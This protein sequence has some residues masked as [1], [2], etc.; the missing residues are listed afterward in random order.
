MKQSTTLVMVGF[1]C[2]RRLLLQRKFFS[3]APFN[4]SIRGRWLS[5]KLNSTFK[6]SD[7]E[8]QLATP[9]QLKPKPDELIFGKNFTDH[10]IQIVHSKALGGWQPPRILPFQ[11]ISLHPAAKVFHYAFELFEGMKA[12]RGVDGRIRLFRPDRNMERMNRSAVAAVLPTFDGE[13][14]V[15]CIR[16]LIEIDQEWVPHSES[17]S[18]Y[19]RPT[20]IG[21]D[22]TLGVGSTDSALLFV[23]L[24]PVGPY[25]ASG[26]KPV[27]LLADAKY[28][29][30]WP[31]GV[32]DCKMGSNYAPTIRVQEIANKNNFQQVV[33][34]YGS[35]HQLTEVGTMNIF[36]F[37]I[38]DDGEK[39]LITPP[40]NGLILPG[41]TRLSILELAW[42]WKEFKVTER[43]I[44]MAEVQKLL[45]EKRLLEI[46][47]A[48]TACIVAPV[49]S[50]FFEGKTLTIPTMDHELPVHQQFLNSLSDIQ[51][52]R[53]E[54]QWAMLID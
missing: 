4:P 11:N 16:R 8:V 27:S 21:T 35:D 50:I 7:L 51:Y 22:P 29:R 53:V 52:G 10:M 44:T 3:S 9:E 31:G 6:Y 45:S 41:V 48:G 5:T 47:G 28:V 42:E 40:L 26:F 37:I 38:N 46:F 24:C 18:L 54:H 12:Y 13:E 33:W 34:L 36:A 43:P 20:L 23:V 49:S 19:I 15:S 17:S 32:G 30:A 1:V 14:L 39:E 25:F 2:V